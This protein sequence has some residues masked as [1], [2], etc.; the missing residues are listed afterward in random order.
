MKNTN[1]KI[2]KSEIKLKAS[3]FYV[4]SSILYQFV[5]F[6]FRFFKFDFYFLNSFSLHS[7]DLDIHNFN[8]MKNLYTMLLKWPLS[9]KIFK[10]STYCPCKNNSALQS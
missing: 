3:Q 4:W 7:T 9:S 1:I 6:D 2:G 8:P 10:S 5:S